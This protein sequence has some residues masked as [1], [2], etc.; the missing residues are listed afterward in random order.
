MKNTSIYPF[1]YSFLTF[2]PRTP[3]LSGPEGK[4]LYSSSYPPPPKKK[5]KNKKQREELG[6]GLSGRTL[7]CHSQGP[8]LV[9]IITKQNG[10]KTLAGC[11][12]DIGFVLLHGRGTCDVIPTLKSRRQENGKIEAS[13]VPRTN[14]V[15]EH[16][17]K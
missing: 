13:L 5:K 4:R 3:G 10:G 2:S 12:E 17:T 14:P 9:P 11:S 1:A 15:S 16:H 8:G 6:L 7:G